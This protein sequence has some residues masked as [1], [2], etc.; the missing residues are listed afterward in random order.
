[1][2]FGLSFQGNYNKDTI[3][4]CTQSAA[5]AMMTI[6]SYYPA[7]TSTSG[8]SLFDSRS[9]GLFVSKATS[10]A[11]LNMVRLEGRHLDVCSYLKQEETSAS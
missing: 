8:F 5:I 7:P 6:F 1:M 2:L 3:P 9:S 10:G 4:A 11:L